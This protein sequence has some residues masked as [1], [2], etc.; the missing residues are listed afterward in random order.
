[1]QYIPNE[2][3]LSYYPVNITLSRTVDP[4]ARPASSPICM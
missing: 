4:M 3:R 1:V 2:I